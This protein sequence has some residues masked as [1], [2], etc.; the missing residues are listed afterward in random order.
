MLQSSPSV[1]GEALS[2][3]CGPA[4]SDFGFGKVSELL[5]I[6]HR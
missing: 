6:M 5:I 4:L 3:I 1:G 2:L